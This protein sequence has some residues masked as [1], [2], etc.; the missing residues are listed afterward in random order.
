MIKNNKIKF[1][2]S[3]IIIL[4]PAIFGLIFWNTLPEHMATHWGFAGSADSWSNKPFAVLILP[5]IL[6]VFHIICMLFASKDPGNKSQNKKA[7]NI[8]YWIVPMISLFSN[9][10]V[11]AVA[12]GYEFSSYSLMFVL[13]GLMF[14][15]IGNY[16]PKCKQNFTLGIKIKWTLENEENWNATHRFSGKIWVIG[17]VIL[18]LA[19]FLPMKAAIPVMIIIL[20]AMVLIPFL[21]SYIYHRKQVKAGTATVT[22]IFNPYDKFSK[23]MKIFS[24][25]ITIA[26]VILVVAV[27]FTGSIS[28]E[29]DDTSF[30]VDSPYW[31]KLTVD[32]DDIDSIEYRESDDPGSRTSGYGSP[33]LLMGQFYNDE[34]GYYTRYS[35]TKC[36]SCIVLTSGESVLVINSKDDTQTMEIYEELLSKIQ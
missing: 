6:L 9:G 16:M 5:L 10:F 1:I 32:Y 3:C 17:G 15:F 24:A 7:L 34:F 18:L 25:V 35:Y 20:A 30:T 33:I 8:V 14:V 22:P 13:M 11:Y 29:V 21:Y 36:D 19:V 28:I 12:L 23:S 4:L 2:I 27:L 31:S 26:V